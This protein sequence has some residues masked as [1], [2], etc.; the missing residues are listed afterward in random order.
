MQPRFANGTYRDCK[1]CGGTGCLA[2]PSEVDKEYKRQF[3]DGPKP[4]A[5]FNLA[6]EKDI[7]KAKH[8]FG[9]DSLEKAFGLEGGGMTEIMEKLAD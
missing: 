3:P 4:I 6:D 7:A 2:C 8:V 1:F 9:K 5:T